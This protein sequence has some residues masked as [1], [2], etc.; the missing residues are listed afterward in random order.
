MLEPSGETKRSLASIEKVKHGKAKIRQ[1][2]ILIPGSATL[3][4]TDVTIFIGVIIDELPRRR[5][6]S[7]VNNVGKKRLQPCDSA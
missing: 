6:P 7:I 1:N 5:H 4:Q 3:L 2:N